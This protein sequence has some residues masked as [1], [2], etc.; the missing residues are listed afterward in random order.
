[1][2]VERCVGGQ[3]EITRV[4]CTCRDGSTSNYSSAGQSCKVV[5]IGRLLS[6]A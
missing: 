5:V 6:A 2:Q 3:T 1:M 4:H